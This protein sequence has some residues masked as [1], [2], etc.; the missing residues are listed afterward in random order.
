MDHCLR[1]RQLGF[2]SLDRYGELTLNLRHA[3]GEG[4]QYHKPAAEYQAAFSSD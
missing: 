2:S 3:L 4:L 1:Q